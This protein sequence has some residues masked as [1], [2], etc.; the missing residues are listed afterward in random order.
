M[1]ASVVLIGFQLRGQEIGEK[2]ES[3]LRTNPHYLRRPREFLKKLEAGVRHILSHFFHLFGN[4]IFLFPLFFG[5]SYGSLGYL[6]ICFALLFMKDTSYF[7]AANSVAGLYSIIY[8]TMLYTFT[9]LKIVFPHFIDRLNVSFRKDLGMDRDVEVKVIFSLFC[10]ALSFWQS[11]YSY[12]SL[13]SKNHLTLDSLAEI[14]YIPKIL[15]KTYNLCLLFLYRHFGKVVAFFICLTAI[16]TPSIPNVCT[17]ML[18]FLFFMLETPSSYL[19]F[20]TMLFIQVDLLAKLIFQ[21]DMLDYDFLKKSKILK[22]CGLVSYDGWSNDIAHGLVAVFCL[23]ILHYAV[24]R[25]AASI[26]DADRKKENIVYYLF[27]VFEEFGFEIMQ[28]GQMLIG[29]YKLNLYGFI[30]ILTSLVWFTR[31][32][33]HQTVWYVQIG[34]IMF[35]TFFQYTTELKKVLEGELLNNLIPKKWMYF[36]GFGKFGFFDPKYL[37]SDFLLIMILMRARLSYFSRSPKLFTQ[38]SSQS[39]LP[40]GSLKYNLYSHNLLIVNIL[41]FLYCAFEPSFLSLI[42]LTGN[43]YF[44]F[45]RAEFHDSPKIRGQ[46]AFYIVFAYIIAISVMVMQFLLLWFTDYSFLNRGKFIFSVGIPV[47]NNDYTFEEIERTIGIFDSGHIIL[48]IS[49]FFFSCLQLKMNESAFIRYVFQTRQINKL[50]M[51]KRYRKLKI[52]Q[53]KQ[54]KVFLAAERNK[55]RMIKL[56]I[57]KNL[58]DSPVTIDDWKKLFNYDFDEAKEREDHIPDYSSMM[59]ERTAFKDDE[60]IR[61]FQASL[62]DEEILATKALEN[63]TR[64]KVWYFAVFDWIICNTYKLSFK[65]RNLRY[66]E[67]E[68]VRIE[69]IVGEENSWKY[70]IYCFLIAMSYMVFSELEVWSF[71]I[72]F[73]LRV[74]VTDFFFSCILFVYIIGVVYAENKST[75]R[76]QLNIF[77]GV[78]SL[79]TYLYAF[80]YIYAYLKGV[81]NFDNIPHFFMMLL[82]SLTISQRDLNSILNPKEMS[83]KVDF[84]LRSFLS[85]IKS[86][87]KANTEF[88]KDYYTQYFLSDL[89]SLL[90][91][92]FFWSSFRPGTSE[93]SLIGMFME[94]R[95]SMAFV[96]AAIANF[97]FLILDRIAYTSKSVMLK[98]F[99][100]YS[101]LILTHVWIQTSLKKEFFKLNISLFVWYVSKCSYW[102]FSAKQIKS[103]YPLFRTSMILTKNATLLNKYLFIIYRAIPYLFEFRAV[104]DWAISDTCLTFYHWLE[105]EDVFGL[106][107]KTKVD[108]QS[109]AKSGRKFGQPVE[110]WFQ[111][112]LLGLL[113]SVFTLLVW[114]PFIVVGTNS[115]S[116]TESVVDGS[117]QF[118]FST[119]SGNSNIVNFPFYDSGLVNAYNDEESQTRY[120]L[121]VPFESSRRWTISDE[122]KEAL[123]AGIRSDSTR[124]CY[125]LK[126]ETGESLKSLYH[127]CFS[128]FTST[129]KFDKSAFA[130]F[131]SA[132]VHREVPFMV[133]SL[134]EFQKVGTVVAPEGYTRKKFYFNFSEQDPTIVTFQPEKDPLIVTTS[135]LKTNLK[136]F[137]LI[138]LYLY[139][140]YAL[141]RLIRFSIYGIA[142]RIQIDELPNV[143]YILDLCQDILVVREFGDHFME[144]TLFWHLISLFRSPQLL[145]E[146]TRIP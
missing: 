113:M 121:S 44:V 126:F 62:F 66:T 76:V 127:H 140:V 80:Y 67:E 139:F 104:I 47:L 6:T 142:A 49:I 21:L 73:L 26:E 27:N 57:E 17:L 68:N 56:N 91:M 11:R 87:P 16:S 81:P 100:Q 103:G 75:S 38:P 22:L 9:L 42:L 108:R 15:I 101:N 30:Y 63:N 119:L 36:L 39:L 117:I 65:Y 92:A 132:G 24:K 79:W 107:F 86:I 70:R 32:R 105:F 130:D 84:S 34:F 138:G 53:E 50:L 69:H 145:I 58:R 23:S 133:E 109:D 89:A 115:I 4:W 3:R 118:L 83:Q 2:I 74:I 128:S 110:K 71:L 95:V 136:R 112:F 64:K 43:L 7:R 99:I 25:A 120:R 137:G 10:F 129:D 35:C 102:I 143:D 60:Q 59:S 135:T 41:S 19:I 97:V 31:L 141:S 61:Y 124:L 94:N 13:Q 29:L 45:R 18:S 146:K 93:L 12:Q 98:V 33:K 144:E 123:V 8:L 72:L 116:E 54:S 46:F 20:S 52:D 134:F 122:D 90:L 88:G 125:L 48:L 114:F 82:A 1:F 78:C 37:I 5:I 85:W 131:I 77:F 51:A 111:Y 55:V 14:S 96:F 28:V 40:T 106:I